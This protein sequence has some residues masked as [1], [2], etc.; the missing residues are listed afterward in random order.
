MKTDR[1]FTLIEILVTLVIIAVMSGG[2]LLIWS[3]HLRDAKIKAT[4]SQIEA[5][6][7]LAQSEAILTNQALVAIIYSD[8]CHFFQQAPFPTTVLMGRQLAW[9]SLKPKAFWQ[10]LAWPKGFKLQVLNEKGQ[11]LT[12]PFQ[13][14]IYP[15]GGFTPIRIFLRQGSQHYTLILDQAGGVELKQYKQDRP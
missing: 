3:S 7:Q 14:I 2:A 6:F 10:T 11:S 13:V 15:T 5:Q 4:L 9:K 8:H 1:A 12:L